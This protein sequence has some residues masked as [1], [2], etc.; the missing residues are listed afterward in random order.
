MNGVLSLLKKTA[1]AC[2]VLLALALAAGVPWAAQK[3]G[4]KAPAPASTPAPASP[5]P[6]SAAAATPLPEPPAPVWPEGPAGDAAR[7]FAAGDIA[8]AR[9]IWEKLAEEGDGQ[10][11]N[12]LGV[13]YDQ[14]QG[15]E[16]DV[17]RALHWF[18]KAAEA[19]NASGMSNYGRMLEQGRGM[20]ANPAEA[21][22]WFDLAARQ[23]Q[24]EAQYNLGFLYEHGRGVPR[25]DAAAAAW[26]SRAASQRQREALGRL[27]HFYRVGRGVAVN[28]QRASLL[29]YAAAM[30]GLPAAIEELRLM[31]GDGKEPAVLFGQKLDTATRAG[32]RE[33]LHKAG[34]APRSE[35][36]GKI[37]DTYDASRVVPGATEMAV[38]YGRGKD[39]RL[40]FIKIDYP[41]PD[42]A[43]AEAI[44]KMVEGRF[45]TP[46]AGEG[47]DSRLWNLGSTLVATQYAPTHGQMSL[48]YMVPAVYHETR[49]AR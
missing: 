23:G 47:E 42:K 40:A 24:P 18:A 34:A 16:P 15:V 5:A 22:R 28:P 21:A 43:R 27:G 46:S 39:A 48:M 9:A 26:Y 20:E 44:L 14:G 13:L 8:K 32:M 37:C 2:A 33:A 45:G 1:L 17:G 10:A 6:A 11:M 7:A 35:D 25:D 12:N 29:L 3:S 38:C 31:A 36:A 4:A 19:G 49:A 30:E 41:A